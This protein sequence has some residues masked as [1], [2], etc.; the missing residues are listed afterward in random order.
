MFGAHSPRKRVRCSCLTPRRSLLPHRIS[1]APVRAAPVWA[2]RFEC[3]SGPEAQPLGTSPAQSSA[4]RAPAQS[5]R[6]QP[7]TQPQPQPRC[8]SSRQN[9]SKRLTNGRKPLGQLFGADG[10]RRQELQHLIFGTRCFNNYA[11]L[12]HCLRYSPRKV[13]HLG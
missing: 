12:E 13:R 9:A 6:A 5:S 11:A 10:E 2:P 7:E 4:A 8:F 1:R 3:P